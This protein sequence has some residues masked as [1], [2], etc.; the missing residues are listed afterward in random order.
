VFKKMGEACLAPG[1]IARTDSVPYL[2]C[3]NWG[4][5]VF[6]EDYLKPVSQGCFVNFIPEVFVS[7]RSA[8]ERK[9]DK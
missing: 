9:K 8:G 4:L 7:E 2:D 5:V 1:F 3:N 6:K